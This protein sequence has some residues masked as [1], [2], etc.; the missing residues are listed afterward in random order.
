MAQPA[1]NCLARNGCHRHDIGGRDER[2]GVI[3][4]AAR[5]DA[6]AFLSRLLRLDPAALVR[7]RPMR[8]GVGA[9]RDVDEARRPADAVGGD[10]VE[11]WAML[12]FG[13]LVGRVVPSGVERDVT[14]SAAELLAT[15]TDHSLPEPPRRDAAWHWPLPSS[16]G[17]WVETV[18]AEAVAQ[19]AAAA[20]RTLREASAHGVA[21]RAVGER[22]L[23]DA[24]LDHVPIVV[25]GAQGERVEVSQRLVQAV[26]QMGFL[27]QRAPQTSASGATFGDASVAV[28]FASAWIGLV[29]MYGCAWYRESPPLHLS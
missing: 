21:G 29:T 26:V 5:V 13:V 16:P 22:V 27:G 14:V 3:G 28:R 12:P 7:L 1:T 15:L 25:T 24:L 17:R 9:G 11:M 18:P 4:V 6:G 10:L 2:D 19:V 23:R 8:A 20:S